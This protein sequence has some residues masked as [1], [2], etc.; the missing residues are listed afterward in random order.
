MMAL[1]SMTGFAR[2]EGESGRYSW[3]WEIRSVNG[4]GLDMRLRLPP[5]FEHLETEVR[6]ILSARFTRGNM[7]VSLNVSTREEKVEAVVNEDALNAILDLKNRLAG[8]VDDKPLSFDTLL[9]MR[10]VVDFRQS[11]ESADA[12]KERDTDIL[13]GLEDAVQAMLE[14]RRKEGGALKTVLMGQ[15]ETLRDLVAQIEKD[16]SRSSAEI[17]ARLQS[18]LEALLGETSKLD[19]TRLHAE[20]ALLATK[21]DI[22]EELDRLK[23]HVI[24]G[25]ELLDAGKPVG[26]KLDFLAQEFNRETNTICSKSNAIAVTTIGLEMKVVIDQ[27]REQVQN[28]E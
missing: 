18:Q 5:G 8:Q 3:V 24:A 21:A 27:F 16:P 9:L 12:I 22:R 25:R 19:E 17:A 7:Q 23:A 4:K 14:S 11:E 10:G 1:Q 28:L 26:R 2:T 13:I 15:L 6:K 20:A